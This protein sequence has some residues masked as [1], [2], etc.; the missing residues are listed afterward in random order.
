MT[1][2]LKCQFYRK[3][4]IKVITTSDVWMTLTYPLPSRQKDMQAWS[5]Y[6]V[7]LN[8]CVTLIPDRSDRITAV[9]I[10]SDSGNICLV[11]VF[12][13]ARDSAGGDEEF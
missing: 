8:H 11:C 13:P 10:L 4:I 5:F 9:D 6:G 12:L 2:I 7:E 3:F 1:F